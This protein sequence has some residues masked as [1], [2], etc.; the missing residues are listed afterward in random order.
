M[1][2]TAHIQTLEN[3]HHQ[4]E[5]QIEEA[6]NHHLQSQ[7]LKKEKL[8]VKETIIKLKATQSWC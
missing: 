7:H 3:K 5:K 2:L 6:H 8:Q 4:L 1:S